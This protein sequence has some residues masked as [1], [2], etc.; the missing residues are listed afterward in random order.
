MQKG[1]CKHYEPV[2]ECKA[3]CD[4]KTQR[5]N[6][7]PCFHADRPCPMA[8]R[9]TAEDEAQFEQHIAAVLGAL[10]QRNA[11]FD[12]AFPNSTQFH[13]FLVVGDDR[14]FTNRQEAL[15]SID[16]SVRARLKVHNGA[17]FDARKWFQNETV[18]RDGD[19]DVVFERIRIARRGENLFMH[20]EAAD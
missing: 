5:F 6:A 13:A 1:H 10:A 2:L 16:P 12:K 15:E 17:H 18:Y 11:A 14:I 9:Y 8:E 20:S 4:L 7:V 19:T 3:G